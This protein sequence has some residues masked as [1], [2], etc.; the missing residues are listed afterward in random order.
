MCKTVAAAV[1][2]HNW[3]TL[4]HMKIL[5]DEIAYDGKYVQ[6]INRHYTDN[7]GQ[8][9]VWELVKRKVF[10]RIIVVVPVTAERE[11]ILEKIY[12]VA[13]G[14]DVLELPAGLMDREGESEEEVVRRE[15]L[16]ETGYSVDK[17]ELL[18]VGPAD[19]GL[20]VHEIAI[21]LGTN[22]RKV[23][24]PSPGDSEV[25][26]VIKVPIDRVMQYLSENA[27]KIMLDIKIAAVIP[28]LS[29]RL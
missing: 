3:F 15:L 17:I 19:P 8:E 16:E 24:D 7:D 28:L 9:R 11:L 1:I 14:R 10:G 18:T 6:I 5:K 22:A 13:L 29:N 21:Y 4:I 20:S 23:Q 25:I 2:L 26:E 27:G 12:R